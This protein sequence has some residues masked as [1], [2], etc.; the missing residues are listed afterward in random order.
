M[1]STA[2]A[3]RSAIEEDR[4]ERIRRYQFAQ[5]PGLEAEIKLIDPQNRTQI[6]ITVKATTTKDLFA[7]IYETMVEATEEGYEI[8]HFPFGAEQPAAP[9][10]APAPEPL[11]E[12][13]Y[14]YEH[15]DADMLAEAHRYG[16]P[17]YL[18][19]LYEPNGLPMTDL[20]SRPLP[21]DPQRPQKWCSVHN[22]WMFHR[23]GNGGQWFSHPAGQKPDGKPNFCK[24][25]KIA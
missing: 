25:A 2:T 13:Q 16:Q 12:Q 22:Q 7:A 9:A 21:T 19:G 20:G 17:A 23:S 3:I 5:N 24:G 8:D 18:A 15:I 10:I 14:T 4:T 6:R 1:S 11:A